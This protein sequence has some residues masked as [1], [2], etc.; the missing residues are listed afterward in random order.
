MLTD[1]QKQILCL[2]VS[3]YAQQ[4]VPVSSQALHQHKLGVSSATIR[5]DLG[6]LEETGYITHPHTSAGRVPTDKGYRY[7]V[8]HLLEREQVSRDMADRVSEIFKEKVHNI[9]EMM[10]KVSKLMSSMTD[11]ASLVIYPRLEAQFFKKVTLISI[12]E[13]HLIVVWISTSG[14]VW[15]N[16]LELENPLEA[17]SLHQLA[18][19]LNRELEGLSFDKIE[20]F[21]IGRLHEARNSLARLYGL[22]AQIVKESLKF[23]RKTE[24]S[25]I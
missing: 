23:L 25:Q 18:N 16:S 17:E 12:D 6:V 15:H 9:D 2:V 14:L 10:R 22:A 11:E 3:E 20:N 8:D 5:N 1:R 13:L 24:F 7:Y 19:L 21:L 4:A